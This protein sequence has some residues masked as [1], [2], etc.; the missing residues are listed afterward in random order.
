MLVLSAER[1]ISLKNI[2]VAT[3]FSPASESAL[4]HAI[5]IAWHYNSK[6]L[7]VHG[8]TWHER[9]QETTDWL[10]CRTDL[11]PRTVSRIG[12]WTVVKRRK[13]NVASEAN[14]GC[15][16]SPIRRVA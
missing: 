6:V 13:T 12:C 9:R 4:D 5:T 7:L 2:L 3:D 11:P 14:P 10:R 1:K 8:N 16:G 15:D